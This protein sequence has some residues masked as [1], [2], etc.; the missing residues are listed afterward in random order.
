MTRAGDCRTLQPFPGDPELSWHLIESLAAAD[1]DLTTCQ[2]MLV[3]HGFVVPMQLLWGAGRAR[4]AR[5]RFT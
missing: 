5:S 4:S 1:F 3:D 2:E